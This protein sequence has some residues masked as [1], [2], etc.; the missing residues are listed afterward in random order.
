[1]KHNKVVYRPTT[2][3]IVG[4]R[5]ESQ[6]DHLVEAMEEGDDRERLLL[7]MQAVRLDP[8]CIDA[9]LVLAEYS[10]DIPTRLGHLEAAVWAGEWLWSSAAEDDRDMSWWWDVGTRPYMRAIH[11]L[12]LAYRDAGRELE[13]QACF[14][15]L[16][17]MAPDDP[18]GIRHLVDV[19]EE[20][21]G[22][23][24]TFR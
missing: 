19:P 17:A 8:G 5:V 13:S 2:G 23:G 11:A 16:L 10:R 21:P 12:G 1:M 18:Q 22:S 3:R 6:A 14:N 20:D 4:R 24:P 9:R 15:R 7:A